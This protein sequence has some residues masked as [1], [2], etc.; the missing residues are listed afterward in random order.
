MSAVSRMEEI[1]ETHAAMVRR[2]ASVYE[3][4]RD[5]VDDLAQEVWIAVWRAVPHLQSEASLKAYIARIAQNVCVTHVRRAVRQRTEPLSQA[6]SDALTD[7]APPVEEVIF[8]SQRL[9]NLLE[10]VRVLPDGLKPVASL[11]LEGLS[12]DEI[13]VALGIS[14]ANA[15][16]RLHRA[17]AA[18]RLSLGDSS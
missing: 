6:L 11:F 18:L 7:S 10:A 12:I 5:R 14:N 17:K 1:V 2:I 8:Q 3:H 9:R 13:A 15:S 16:V 4:H